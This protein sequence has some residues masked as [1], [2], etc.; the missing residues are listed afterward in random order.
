MNHSSKFYQQSCTITL[1]TGARA[2]MHGIFKR[3]FVTPKMIARKVK[4]HDIVW[5]PPRILLCKKC[6]TRQEKPHA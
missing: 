1:S 5:H 3:P 4:Y 2:V 6:R